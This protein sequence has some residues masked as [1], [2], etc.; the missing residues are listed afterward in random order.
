MA[1]IDSLGNSFFQRNRKSDRKSGG[2]EKGAP[3]RRSFLEI[4]PVREDFQAEGTAPGGS[5]ASGEDL[6]ALLDD[7]HDRGERLKERPTMERIREYREAV[8]GFLRYVVHYSFEA[9][10]VEGARFNP[11]KKQKRYTLVRVVNEKLERLAAGVLAN[12]ITQLELLR[13]VEEIN[14]LLV[15]LLQ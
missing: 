10:T 2:V 14:G 3:V 15:D 11:M 4:A 9:E 7:V 8:S 1:K 6:E 5:V 12:Q 13:R